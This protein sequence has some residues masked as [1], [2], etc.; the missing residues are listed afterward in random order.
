MLTK[1]R[2]DQYLTVLLV[3]MKQHTWIILFE[4]GELYGTYVVR[5]ANLSRA[6]KL[7]FHSLCHNEWTKLHDYS[8]F[9]S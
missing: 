2:I 4:A 1:G 5:P 6:L 7:V 8:L 3:K 9:K